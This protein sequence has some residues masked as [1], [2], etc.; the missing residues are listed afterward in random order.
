MIEV[1]TA[2]SRAGIESGQTGCCSRARRHAARHR[3][4]QHPSHSSEQIG[5]SAVVTAPGVGPKGHRRYLGASPRRTRPALAQARPDREAR[6]TRSGDAI[7]MRAAR[8]DHPPVV[9][10]GRLRDLS[11]SATRSASTRAPPPRGHE[12]DVGGFLG[13]RPACSYARVRAAERRSGVRRLP[14]HRPSAAPRRRG[15][16][17]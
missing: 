16:G 1:T 7:A 10:A 14:Y 8:T 15:P 12:L 11:R 17:S 4:R 2:R 6:R 5:G 9:A 13:P 3:P